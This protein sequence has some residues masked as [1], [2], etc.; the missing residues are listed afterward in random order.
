MV[1]SYILRSAGGSSARLRVF[2]CAWV[3]ILA[4]VFGSVF[5]LPSFAQSPQA[6]NAS[7]VE[8][9]VRKFGI[10]KD[11]KIKLTSGEKLRGH[12]SS[13]GASSFTVKLRKSKMERQVP[14]NDVAMVKDP[15]ALFWIL[16]GAAIVV[17]VIVAVH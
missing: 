9:Q 3:S 17:I 11:V 5:A 4:V 6:A 12:I 8:A 10:G 1:L 13:I 14:Y 16:V 2:Q 15:G 7:A